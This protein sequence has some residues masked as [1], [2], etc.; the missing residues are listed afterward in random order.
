MPMYDKAELA[1]SAANYGFHRDAFEKVLR[2]RNVLELFQNEELLKKHFALKGGTAINLTIFPLP[3][4]SVDIDMDY[5]PNDS[6]KDMMSNREMIKTLLKTNMES[7]GYDLSVSSR[8]SHSLDAF[9]FQYYN[10]AGNKDI[11]KI[12]L[13]YSLRSHVFDTVEREILTDAFGERIKVKT[14]HPIEIFAAKANALVNRA[15]ARDLYDFYNL[16]NS[17]L[18]SVERERVLLRK[19]IVFYATITAETLNRYYDTSAIDDLS[20]A[21]IRRD[22]FP[23]LTSSEANR[24]F[25]LDDYK[26]TSKNY[27]KELMILTPD[28]EKYVESFVRGEY[29]PELLFSDEAIV[30]R[31]VN[32]PMAIWKCSSRYQ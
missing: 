26:D 6:K 7:E 21:R 4:L 9:L 18:F 2:L 11:I 17:N 24:H 16:A 23:V 1:A 12:E 29:K 20:F 3:R 13:N 8:F 30:R 5:I 31:I 25:E 14:L 19:T 10:A 15:A 28:E 32:H 27:L 22:L